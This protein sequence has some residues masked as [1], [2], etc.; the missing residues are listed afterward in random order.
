[1]FAIICISNEMLKYCPSPKLI[2]L[3]AK[4]FD[5]MIN[6]QIQPIGFNVSVLKPILKNESKP[7][8]DMS[9]KLFAIFVDD[10]IKDLEASGLGIRIG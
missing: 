8:D 4:F 5:V 10:L 3:L 6:E 2:P 9:P 7:N 1:M